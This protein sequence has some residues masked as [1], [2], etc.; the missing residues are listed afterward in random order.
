VRDVSWEFNEDGGD[1]KVTFIFSD[2]MYL[3]LFLDEEEFCEFLGGLNH[4]EV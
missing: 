1:I 3:D 4:A 2:G